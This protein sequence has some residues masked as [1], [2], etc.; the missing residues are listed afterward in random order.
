MSRFPRLA[1]AT[2]VA[3]PYAALLGLISVNRRTERIAQ[4]ELPSETSPSPSPF[5]PPSDSGAHQRLNG[6]IKMFGDIPFDPIEEAKCPTFNSG[7]Y[8]DHDPRTCRHCPL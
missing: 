3:A 8:P 2:F 5:V 1:I 6:P 7:P 4:F